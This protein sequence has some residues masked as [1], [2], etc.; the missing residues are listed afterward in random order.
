MESTHPDVGAREGAQ[1]EQEEA[2]DK[3]RKRSRG[4][5]GAADAVGGAHAAPADSTRS[6]NAGASAASVGAHA[7][8]VTSGAG[9]AAGASA[10]G[11][12]VAIGAHAAPEAAGAS[13]A[14]AGAHAA[15]ASDA[16][17]PDGRDHTSLHDSAPRAN[18]IIIALMVAALVLG[19][20]Q[21]VLEFVFYG[22]DL[23]TIVQGETDEDSPYTIA[24]FIL[25]A[26]N[27][28]GLLAVIGFDHKGKI[29]EARMVIRVLV[30]LMVV[31]AC[32][33]IILTGI[34]WQLSFYLVQLVCIVA[35]QVYNDPNLSRPPRFVNIKEGKAARAKVY[36]LDPDHRGYI[37]LNFFNLFWVF[38]VA[39]VG[40]LIFETVFVAITNG[41]WKNRTCMLWGPFSPIYGIGAVLMT[42]VVNRWWYCNAVVIFLIT[43]V[44][45][46]AFEYFTSWFM[47]TAFGVYSWDYTGS[48]LSLNGRTDFAHFCGWGFLGVVWVRLALPSVMRLVD[49]IPLKWRSIVTVIVTAFMLV[50]AAMT[51][52][53]IDCWVDRVNGDPIE[54]VT[55][56]Y[57]AEYYDDDFMENRFETFK[58]IEDE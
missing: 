50:D 27:V 17:P 19:G 5:F 49:M 7:A 1:T 34:S 54:T 28:I 22:E 2:P 12:A 21:F 45:G 47:E 16:R 29:F 44:V 10:D 3:P 20:V 43:G 15:A 33:Q 51:L 30:V 58:W 57:F 46:A 35:Y 38:M 13:A 31:G 36:E 26:L 11:A 23:Y 32:V 18:R 56:E 9:A 14:T 6:A 25:T 8:S 4:G 52:M 37:P 41:T 40:G 48:F 24:Y 39:A 55:Q 53:A 42:V